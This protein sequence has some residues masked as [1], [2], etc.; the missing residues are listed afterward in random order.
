[1]IS[2]LY[3]LFCVGVLVVGILFLYYL[4][5]EHQE[6][7]ET[8]KHQII[9][10]VTLLIVPLF[11]RCILDF[12]GTLDWWHDIIYQST[13][14]ITAFNLCFFLFTTYIIVLSQTASLIFGVLRQRIKKQ[15][16]IVKEQLSKSLKESALQNQ[17]NDVR[18]DSYTV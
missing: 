2:A 16:E 8:Y 15:D 6:F 12:M 9:G 5:R 7:Y 18:S 1:M 17:I 11:L 3:G 13:N 14:S 4:Q 10:A